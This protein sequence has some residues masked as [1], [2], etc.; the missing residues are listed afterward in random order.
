M[1]DCSIGTPCD[2]PPRAVVDALASSGTERGYPA[3][4]GSPQLREAAAA[5][6][7]PPLRAG[8][9][10]GDVGRRLRGDQGAG[11]LRAARPP[12]AR[13]GAGH[14]AV[15]RRLVPDLRHGRRAGR[16]PRRP[17]AARAG[18]AGRP[19]PRRRSSPPTPTRALVLW[20]NSPSNPTGGL[21]RPRGGGGLG[22]CARRPG[23]L[24]RVLR[25]VHLGRPAALGARAR[26]R[27]R[28]GGALAL[29]ALEPGR[30]ARRLL[31]RGR[32]A[33]RVPAGRAPARRAHG[34]R[35]GTGRR[36][37]RP[38]RRRRTWT[39]SGR[40]TASAWSTWA[41][42]WAPTAARSCPPRAASTC[43]CRCRR[44]AGP[45]RGPW[46]RRWP[47]TAGSSSAPGDLYGDGRRGARAGGGG[48]AHGAVGAGGGAPR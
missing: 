19:R 17:R 15:P 48:P 47:P 44:T 1:V 24:R 38:G 7:D 33:G 4:A 6:L 36:C 35:T 5:W 25:R 16:V 2:P 3:S 26:T 22:R 43:G 9:G 32:R 27:R 28:G 18:T 10:A 14:G 39:S 23:L 42:S 30:R 21:G 40:A 34:P 8:R 46:P 31:R 37:G 12:P 13:A 41:G 29:Q 11:R 20:S 45:T